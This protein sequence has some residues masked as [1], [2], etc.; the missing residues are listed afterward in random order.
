M[1]LRLRLFLWVGALFIAAFVISYIW[2]QRVTKKS[3]LQAK[4]NIQSEI[5]KLNEKKRR[6]IELFLRDILASEQARINVLLDKVAENQIMLEG[7]EPTLKNLARQTWL[8]SSLL[9]TVNRWVDFIQNTNQGNLS[10]LIAIDDEKVDVALRVPLEEDIALVVLKKKGAT[11]AWEGPYIGVRLQYGRFLLE[12][13]NQATQAKI[14]SRA[15][16]AFFP[17][18]NLLKMRIDQIDLQKLD[19][20][21]QADISFPFLMSEK[22][23]ESYARAFLE[24]LQKAQNYLRVHIKDLPP[25]SDPKELQKWVSQRLLADHQSA[26]PTEWSLEIAREKALYGEE[27]DQDISEEI[28]QLL[29]RYDEIDMVWGLSSLLATGLLGYSPFDANA[30]IGCARFSAGEVTGKGIY[31]QDV[32]ASSPLSLGHDCK[33]DV[34]PDKDLCLSPELEVIDVPSMQRTFF[35]NSMQMVSEASNGQREGYLTVGVDSKRVLRQLSMATHEATV[36]VDGER[37]V[38]VFDSNGKRIDNPEWGQLPVEN[39]VSQSTGVVQIGDTEYFYLHMAPF[40]EVDFH[41]FIFNPKDK[42]FALVDDLDESSNALISHIS[43][44]MRIASVVSLAIVLLFLNNIAKRI[45]KPIVK[46]A[47]ATSMVGKGKLEDVE[48][49]EVKAGRRDEVSSLCYTFSK[50]VSELKD[51]EKVR[52]VLNKVVSREIAEEILKGNVH[53]GGE[54]REVTV[55]FADIRQFTHLTE[56][57]SPNQVIELL[58]TC[59]TKVS[60]CLD[61]FGGV[62]DKYVGDEVMALFGAPVAKEDS[63]KRAVQSALAVVEILNEWNKE[64]QSH[65]QPNIEMGIGVHTGVVLA[66]NMGAENRLNYTVLGSNVNLSS[67]LCSVA[68]PMQVYISE[69]TKMSPGVQEAFVLEQVSDVELKGF[70]EKMTVYVVKGYQQAMRS[71]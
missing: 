10:S 7:F 71:T 39:M 25:P 32:F 50:M 3:L 60:H 21:L 14:L 28:I 38:S 55:L 2:E 27:I 62:I 59:M 48:L 70:S 34:F 35:A 45:T 61:E 46:L 63:A 30:P 8:N 17:I 41:F 69:A 51:K 66:G 49:P 9:C 54:E 20:R 15:R 68:P 23:T 53:L 12:D 29:D 4:Q 42:E 22:A 6:Y 31:S 64:R 11:D 65:G 19:T 37:V 56:K 18:N 40:P 52:G 36:L 5:V 44:Q 13:Q 47:H 67:R 33:N 26:T 58:N 43:L 1:G 24:N 16:Y 57:M